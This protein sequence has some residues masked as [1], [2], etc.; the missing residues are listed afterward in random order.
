MLPGGKHC[1]AVVHNDVGRNARGEQ[2]Q[3]GQDRED[4]EVLEQQ[5][6]K[7]RLAGGSLQLAAL[8]QRLEHDGGGGE[9]E[10]HPRRE[11]HARTEPERQSEGEN[12]DGS[13][14]E[15]QAAE[16]EQL[17]AHAPQARR[18]Q[19]EA[20]EEEHHHHTELGE[21]HHIA[22]FFAHEV[23]RVRADDDAGEKVAEHGTEAEAFREW[24]RHHGGKQVNERVQ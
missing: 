2:R 7:G 20:H 11:G 10:N 15:L 12:G 22:R 19:L 14:G 8:L 16:A 4:G 9:R 13:E 1:R 23:E 17:H 21:V 24:H 5:H 3:Q 18:L 6:R